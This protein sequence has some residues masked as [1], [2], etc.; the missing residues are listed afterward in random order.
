MRCLRLDGAAAAVNI[1]VAGARVHGSNAARRLAGLL[2]TRSD[3]AGSSLGRMARALVLPCVCPLR[4]RASQPSS[5]P[6]WRPFCAQ[7]PLGK[8]RGWAR[9]AHRTSAAGVPRLLPRICD[10]PR[11]LEHVS[12]RSLG[13]LAVSGALLRSHAACTRPRP[14]RPARAFSFTRRTILG[15]STPY[16]RDALD[17]ARVVGG[18]A[19]DGDR[20]RG[21][22]VYVCVQGPVLW[23]QDHVYMCFFVQVRRASVCASQSR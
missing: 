12:V 9:C 15:R 11:H 6:Q 3:K 19:A 1:C 5:L 21:A 2:L 18:R 14:Q 23:A 16:P 20:G 4:S 17:G 8:G 22:R 7:T 10:A 13:D